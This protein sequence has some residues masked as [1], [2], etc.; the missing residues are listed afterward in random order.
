MLEYPPKVLP[1]QLCNIERLV[2]ALKM[3]NLDGVVV[4]SPYN[5]YY[6][7]G[8]KG[9]AHKSDEPRPY[10]VIVARDQP[11]HPILV[12]ADYYVGSLISQPTWI[13]DIRTFRAVMLPLDLPAQ[14]DD[15]DRF[16][17]DGIDD[18]TWSGNLRCHYAM[19]IVESCR[20]ALI[21]LGIG[22]GRVAFDDQRFGHQLAMDGIEVVDGYDPMMYARCVKTDA[23]IELLK[24]A[25]SVNEQA[26]CR[27][28]KTWD[29]GMMWQDFNHEYHR[30]VVDLGGFVRDPGA[31]VWGHPCGADSAV[32]LQSRLDDF[33]MR[34]GVHILFD[35]HG[36]LDLYCWDGGKT[37]IVDG[38]AAGDAKQYADVT[39]LAATAVMESM[40][41][42]ITISELQAVGRSVY[43]KNGVARADEV[44]IFFHGLGLSHMELE[45]HSV[46]GVPNHDWR[47][48]SNMI[49][50]I[51]IL[52]PGDEHHRI[53][54]E[55]VVQVTPDG[56]EPFFSWGLDPLIAV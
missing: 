32:T 48:V 9:I 17:P 34:S 16:L 40:R 3:R 37:W 56:G 43:R 33:E 29:R 27:A 50:P 19:N 28:I 1:K 21:D 24:R 55:E 10:A 15:L 2:D 18:V 54:L 6:L 5:M 46:D 22:S 7:S 52:Y 20:E 30:A 8:F 49:V 13:E 36:T 26:I 47:L 25:T 12:V 23:E 51:H 31:M 41:P 14:E 11:D 35:C 44:L 42:G 39:A 45:Q 4:N 53:W 38:E